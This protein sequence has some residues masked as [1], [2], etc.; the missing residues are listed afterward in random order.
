MIRQAAP[1]RTAVFLRAALG[2]VLV[3]AL[4]TGCADTPATPATPAAPTGQP[5][6]DQARRTADVTYAQ[7]L[8]PHVAQG[9]ELTEMVPGRAADPALAQLATSMNYTDVEEQGQ[10]AGQL[11]L[12]GAP[13]P[14]EDG[15]PAARMPGMADE[16]TLQGLRGL[17][18]PAFDRAWLAVMITHHQGGIDM[19]DDYLARGTD[20]ALATVAQTQIEVGGRQ[21]DQ[22]R[23]L[24]R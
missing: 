2:A 22:M 19:S 24:L 17:S 23:A 16:A 5:A 15:T 7:M 12:W 13:V 14:G 6:P 8:T 4:A 11:H 3:A 21:V 1:V 9:V 10:L 20:Q 18:G